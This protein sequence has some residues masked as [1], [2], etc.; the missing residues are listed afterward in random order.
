M[1]WC[2]VGDVVI[3]RNQKAKQSHYSES[4]PSITY[5]SS[6][7]DVNYWGFNYT[8]FDNSYSMVDG[9]YSLFESN[10]ASCT[11][12]ASEQYDCVNAN[13]VKST[14]YNTPGIYASIEECETACGLG[15]SGQCVPKSEWNKIQSLANQLK[16]KNCS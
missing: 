6:P 10:D 9:S 4:K 1:G 14:K 2:V 5:R 7:A 8:T 15:C 11:T 12:S 3:G 13:C 16:N